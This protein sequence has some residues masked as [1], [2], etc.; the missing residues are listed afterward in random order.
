MAFYDSYIVSVQ[1]PKQY[2][3]EQLQEMVNQEFENASTVQYDVMEEDSFGSLTF[4]PVECRINSLVD[5]KTGQRNNDDYRKIIFKD[6]NKSPSI[7]TRYKFENN[8]WICFSTD[9]IKTDTSSAYLRRCN[10]VITI[11]DKYG[12]IHREPCYIDYKITESQ[13]FQEYTMTTPA[14]RIWVTCQCNDFTKEININDRYIFNDDVY[15]VRERNRFDRSF[16]F[17]K[18]S[19]YMVSFYADVDSINEADRFDIDVADYFDPAYKVISESNISNIVG[20]TGKINCHVEFINDVV[21]EPVLYES[22]NL[23]VCKINQYNGEYEFVGIGECKIYCRLF[24]NTDIFSVVDIN[25]S[26][27]LDDTIYNII[28]PDNHYIKLN[29]E[30][31]YEV[32][33]YK[34]HNKLDSKFI[35]KAYNVPENVFDFNTTDN[36]FTVKYKRL[37]EDGIIKVVCTNLDTN[38][39]I[40][41]YIELGGIW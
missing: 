28:T 14:G 37:Y 25:V 20:Y 30:Q 16:T 38:E 9:N 15:R 19:A 41:F 32:Y 34:N 22:T 17:Q 27:E 21:N 29:T 5:A 36:G 12:K 3:K 10:N 24:N 26:S 23:N 2:W 13:L 11:E 7:G 18:D 4:H 40:D 31:S 8:I 6:L 33:A 1:P 39:S 35:I